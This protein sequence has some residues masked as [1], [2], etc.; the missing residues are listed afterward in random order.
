MLGAIY[1]EAFLS[2]AFLCGEVSDYSFSLLASYCSV[3][4]LCSVF[5]SDSVFLG[6]MCL[7]MYLLLL[8]CP[9]WWKTLG[10]EG[11]LWWSPEAAEG[12]GSEVRV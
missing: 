12:R 1:D 2:R 10:T 11:P 7:E 6:C 8:C 3:Q 9:M 5:F 4:T